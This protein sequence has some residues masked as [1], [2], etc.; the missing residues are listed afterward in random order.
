[1]NLLVV[2]AW[3]PELERFQALARAAA[4]RTAAV[5]VGLVEASIGTTTLLGAGAP[6]PDAVVLI[7]TCGALPGSGLGSG[8]VVSVA[9]ARLVDTSVLAGRADLPPPMP[10]VEEADGRLLARLAPRVG[11]LASRGAHAVTALTT[12]GITTDDAMAAELAPH[13]AIEH[14]EV[15]AV[16]RACAVAGVPWCAVLG[17][18][19]PVG[20][21]G[22]AA[23]RANHVMASA[24]AAEVAYEALLG[25]A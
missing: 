16:A 5:G 19:N 8:D 20:A 24:R 17:V 13:G 6:A 25:H 7:G 15:F 21:A 12:L 3:G 9:R 1:M 23:W 2:A 18:A 4:A 10:A 11:S 22:R 14:L